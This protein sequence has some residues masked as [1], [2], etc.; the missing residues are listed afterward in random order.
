RGVVSRC[1]PSYGPPC[2]R[3]RYS[4]VPSAIVLTVSFCRCHSRPTLQPTANR[5]ETP[6][7]PARTQTHI[8]LSFRCWHPTA[9]WWWKHT[10]CRNNGVVAPAQDPATLNSWPTRDSSEPVGDV[11]RGGAEEPA[12]GG[13]LGV[14]WMGFRQQR[15]GCVEDALTAAVNHRCRP[16]RAR[17]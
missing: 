6:T 14:G 13:Q 15:Y 8:A 1:A 11:H 7:P 3:S 9:P 2:S 12:D 10:W 17:R 4:A 16:C 5:T